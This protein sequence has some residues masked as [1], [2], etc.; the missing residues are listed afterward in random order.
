MIIEYNPDNKIELGKIPVLLD[1]YAE[2]CGPCKMTS[3]Y[4]SE[5]AKNYPDVPIYKINVDENEE[6]TEKWNVQ[7]LPTLIYVNSDSELW[8]H[9]GL[10]T[11]KQLEIKIYGS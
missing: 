3:S 5:F 6:L 2:W 11:T 9:N 7:S 1:F 10:L 4:L 8:R